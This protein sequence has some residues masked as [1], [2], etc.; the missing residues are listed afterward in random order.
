MD[1]KITRILIALAVTASVVTAWQVNEKNKK[2][3]FY[4]NYPRGTIRIQV[5]NGTTIEGLA[6]KVT[7][8]LRRNGFD[9]VEFGN[10]GS[11]RFEK[12]MVIDHCGD[13]EAKMGV[14]TYFLKS[15][16]YVT[17]YDDKAV[18]EH[19]DA[20]VILGSDALD[21]DNIRVN[22]L[23]GGWPLDEND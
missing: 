15:D 20:T 4:K 8:V 21:N 6:Y 7:K 14:L 2:A 16:G 19:V 1:K 17:I 18:S 12:T 9:V 13:N 23:L 5:L 11:V 3:E 10:A 22:N